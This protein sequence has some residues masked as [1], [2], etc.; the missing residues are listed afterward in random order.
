MA[1][2]T[3]KLHILSSSGVEQ[4]AKIY[5]TAA[6][7]G[8]HWLFAN[9]DGAPA[10]IPIGD[11]ND[12]RAT[13]CRVR[14]SA[15]DEYA[16][17]TSATKPVHKVTL[18][19]PA[20]GTIYATYN[21]VNYYGELNVEHGDTIT[22]TCVPN[23]GYKFVTFTEQKVGLT[24]ADGGVGYLGYSNG[25]LDSSQEIYGALNPDTFWAQPDINTTIDAIFV[26]QSSICVAFKA[27]NESFYAE[28][29]YLYLKVGDLPEAT[30]AFSYS[31]ML[32]D[33]DLLYFVCS[34]TSITEQYY[35]AFGENIGNTLT[36]SL[37]SSYDF[38]F[39]GEPLVSPEFTIN[40]YDSS[41]KTTAVTDATFEI[42]DINGTSIGNGICGSTVLLEQGDYYVNVTAAGYAINQFW[43]V[44]SEG[45]IAA[46]HLNILL[47]RSS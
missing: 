22:I 46:N 42:F 23:S 41:S 29:C 7:V 43:F 20:N 36:Y 12:S 44:V 1:E 26:D 38:P 33:V 14:G 30:L 2:L 8:N 47:E 37:M 21:G 5:S 9:I 45:G 19:K 35:S 3:K 28:E 25:Q 40:A 32:D 16:V 24:I 31:V 17:L 34:D 6:E 13:S 15:G 18:N 10:Y 11:I 27:S 39:N 4:T